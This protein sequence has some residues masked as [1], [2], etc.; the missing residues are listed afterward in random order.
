MTGNRICC[1]CSRPASALGGDVSNLAPYVFISYASADRERVL[2]IVAAL[3][4]T[5]ISCWLDQHGIEGGANWGQRITEAI[6]GCAVFVLMSSTS[7]LASRNVRQEVAVAWKF[8]KPYL[9]LLLDPTP[10]PTEL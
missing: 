4:S 6:E 2:T 8:G 10:V 7:S 3:R 1:R 9:P 5:G